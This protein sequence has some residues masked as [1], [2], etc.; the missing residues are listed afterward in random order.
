HRAARRPEELAER[1]P[2]RDRVGPARHHDARRGHAAASHHGPCRIGARVISRTYTPKLAEVAD[3]RRTLRRSA[4]VQ[5]AGDVPIDR[6]VAGVAVR[7]DVLDDPRDL[8]RAHALD[9]LEVAL[10][11]AFVERA[12]FLR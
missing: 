4:A 6:G 12:G 10:G 7:E 9:G 2:P 8:L 1:G 5:S 11:D 3:D